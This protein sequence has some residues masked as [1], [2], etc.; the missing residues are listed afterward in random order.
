MKRSRRALVLFA[1]LVL[2]MFFAVPAE[3]VPETAYDESASLPYV[4]I[5]VVSLAGPEPVVA[6]SVVSSAVPECIAEAATVRPRASR[7]RFGLQRRPG[8]RLREG[9]EGRTGW[10]HHVFDS[11]TILDHCLRC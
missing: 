11:L 7:L 2:T 6:A 9:G 5:R 10:A 8:A 3:D 4:S 1:A